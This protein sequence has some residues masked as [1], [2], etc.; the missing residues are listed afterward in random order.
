MRPDQSV[1]LTAT[2]R[3]LTF[4]VIKTSS[5]RAL[6]ALGRGSSLLSR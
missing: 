1:E 6:L 4:C 2:R 3:T 5:V